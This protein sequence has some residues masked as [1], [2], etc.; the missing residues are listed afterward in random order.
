[1]DSH[2]GSILYFFN[3]A[4]HVIHVPFESSLS[5]AISRLKKSDK[6]KKPALI[7]DNQDYQLL[8]T[9][10]DNIVYK[11]NN[12]H[13]IYD[14]KK[15]KIVHTELLYTIPENDACTQML[16]YLDQ[17]LISTPTT[18]K[19]QQEELPLAIVEVITMIY[20]VTLL[21]HHEN[22]NFVYFISFNAATT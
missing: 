10:N 2:S 7:E 9:L 12:G 6:K 20:R 16:L 17:P 19:Q 3:Q 8:L 11:T 21:N 14:S 15:V 22:A 1:M 13:I 5:S 18:N 4:S